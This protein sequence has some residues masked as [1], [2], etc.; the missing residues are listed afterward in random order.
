M[1]IKRKCATECKGKVEFLKCL[2]KG[3]SVM[4]L[5]G[6]Y[7]FD[8]PTICDLKKQEHKIKEQHLRERSK[9]TKPLTLQEMLKNDSK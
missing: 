4:S 3:T 8:L 5:C 9:L 1:C 6:E 2:D 7:G